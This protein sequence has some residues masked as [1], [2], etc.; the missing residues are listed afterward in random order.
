MLRMGEYICG[1]KP[2][3]NL[4]ANDVRIT[5]NGKRYLVTGLLSDKGLTMIYKVR[6][7][8]REQRGNFCIKAVHCPF[9]R[10]EHVAEAMR[11]ID[12]YQAFHSPYITSLLDSQIVPL[13]QGSKLVYMV[14]QYFPTGSLQQL[15]DTTLVEGVPLPEPRV[16]ALMV[17]VCRAV[18]AVHQPGD[19]GVE[20]GSA[21]QSEDTHLLADALEMDVLEA[22][23]SSP[24]RSF[25]L[26]DLRPSA[27]MLTP[28]GMPIISDLSAC[29]RSGYAL[30]NATRLARMRAVLDT[31]GSPMYLA[32]ELCA[33]EPNAC[34]LP[35]ADIWS[36][37]CICYALM[38]GISPFEREEQLHGTPLRQARASGLFSFPDNPVYSLQLLDIV[39]QCLAVKPDARP[40]IDSLMSLFHDLLDD[41]AIGSLVLGE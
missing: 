33:L 36:L 17:E 2:L 22:S 38:Y 27:V 26:C 3:W 28:Q 34:I 21:T 19:E 31:H 20:S 41:S 35:P 6:S 12:N 18:R 37:G 30:A 25:V 8:Q 39:R 7:L 4:W 16:L 15:I 23:T 10:A 29:V 14:L 24:R 32:P 9:G 40:T 13:E 5:V 1:C 11:E